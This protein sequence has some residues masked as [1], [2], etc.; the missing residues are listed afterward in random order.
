MTVAK[1]DAMSLKELRKYVLSHREDV[2]AFQRYID[3]SKAEDNMISLDLSDDQWEEKVKAAIR[4]S[5]EAVRWY[6]SD[7]K[8]DPEFSEIVKW[9]RNLA[10]KTVVIS[11]ITGMEIDRE[12]GIWEPVQLNPQKQVTILE[13][14]IEVVSSMAVV[15]YVDR[16]GLCHELEAIAIDLDLAKN[17][18][19]AWLNSL[20][21]VVVFHF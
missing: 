20:D 7:G 3:R 18:F 1:Y 11:H 9:W 13:S 14:S 15:K 6:H 12:T 19:F 4:Y 2:E 21:E 5:S 16:D 17:N 10:H 8:N